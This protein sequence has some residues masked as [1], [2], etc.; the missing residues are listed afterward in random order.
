[1]NR[2][3]NCPVERQFLPAFSKNRPRFTRG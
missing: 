2:V 1:M 3:D